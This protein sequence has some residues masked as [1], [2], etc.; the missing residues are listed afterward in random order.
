MDEKVYQEIRASFTSQRRN[1]IVISIVL[2]IA[3]IIGLRFEKISLFGNSAQLNNPSGAEVVLWIVFSYMLIRY[4]QYFRRWENKGFKTEF[5]CAFE[6][7]I[8]RAAFKKCRKSIIPTRI[9]K[10]G[11]S[12]TDV[13]P[14][15]EFDSRFDEQGCTVSMQLEWFFEENGEPKS[16]SQRSVV[17]LTKGQLRRLRLIAG[18]DLTLNTHLVTEYI[19]PFALALVPIGLLMTRWILNPSG[20]NDVEK[21]IYY[22]VSN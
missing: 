9:T 15:H 4:Y 3:Q 19:L 2:S 13:K 18:L 1:L 8:H 22:L 14:G 5:D 6:R 7:A 20:S 16:T 10:D 11:I 12:I 17:K 21:I